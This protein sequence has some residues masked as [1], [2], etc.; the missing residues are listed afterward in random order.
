M[1]QG[2]RLDEQCFQTYRP[3]IRITTP[4]EGEDLIDEIAR[5]LAGTA[6]LREDLAAGLLSDASC[7][8]AISA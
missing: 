1:K 3:S 7:P 2:S 6:D 4:A 5:P 8:S